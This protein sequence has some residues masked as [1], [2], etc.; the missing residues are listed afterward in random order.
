[1]QNWGQTI[2]SQFGN[3]PVVL[4]LI[5][6][7]NDCVDPSANIDAFYDLVWNIDTAQG[8]G[9]DVWGRIVGVIRVLK[10]LPT[11]P[12]PKTLGFDEMGTT[13]ADPFNQSPFYAGPPAAQSYTLSDA[14]FR[15]L[16]FVKALSNISD[17][18]IPS[19]NRALML[20]F[21]GRG[22]V[23]VTDTGGMTTTFTFT[24]AL[25]D[26]EV[27]ILKQSG[28]LPGPTGVAILILDTIGYR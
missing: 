5:E 24:F 4:S 17:R 19:L 13:D 25:T 3:S 1:M 21:P 2:L 27:A 8:Y 12:Q 26:V 14:A 23:Y 28:A 18:S 16:V 11:G 10:V 6:S 20:L 7:F 15:T 22:N 9:I